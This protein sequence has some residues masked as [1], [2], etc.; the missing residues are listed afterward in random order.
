MTLRTK[1][2][3]LV[4]GLAM[5][6]LGGVWLL[7]SRSW[8]A[9][10]SDAVDRDLL[11]RSEALQTMVEVKKDG[12]LEL[13][14]EHAPAVSD[15]SHPFRISGLAE[16]ASASAQF[17]WPRFEAVTSDPHM[18]TV[19][20]RDGGRWR[21]V[22]RTLALTHDKRRGG[23]EP[24]RVIVQVAGPAE[25]YAAVEERFR[26][27]LLLAISGALLVGGVGAML[28]VHFSLA[29]LSRLTQDIG[30]IGATSL[31]RRVAVE[32]LDPELAR[33]ATAFNEMLGRLEGAMQRQ[34]EFVSRASHSLRTPISI[35]LA[36]AE[37]AL[38][39]ERDAVAYREAMRDVAAAARESASLVAH[40]LTLARLDER[41]CAVRCEPVM[42]A[43]VARDVERLLA[44]RAAEAGVGL[45]L[46]V[47]ESL[48]AMAERA[49][50]RELLEALVDN[51]LRYTP[52]GGRAG[53]RGAS[54][55]RGCSLHVWDTGPGISPDERARLFERF[56]R[57]RTG[58][59]S[60]APG[61]G[62]GLSIVKAI[63]DACGATVSLQDHTGGGLEVVVTFLAADSSSSGSASSLSRTHERAQ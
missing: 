12:R 36:R 24:I 30:G 32:G 6:L 31:E 51:A 39:R 17:E 38:R 21:V 49:T 15:P 47:P 48:V 34:R 37:V 33:L 13:E 26:R 56:Q 8:G 29:P 60:G 57:G 63:A 61:S 4:V 54:T 1:I 23:Q 42:V 58:Q 25:P 28:L 45:E 18:S 5:T 7:L 40:L 19:V 52:R 20:G 14:D 53:I 10:S 11:A 41:Q 50:L 44:T 43:E 62:L 2:V 22:S 46:D 16:L 35:I 27:G 55:A 3:A 59:T 9:W